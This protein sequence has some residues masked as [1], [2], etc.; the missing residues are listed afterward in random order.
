[1]QKLEYSIKR[2]TAVDS[3]TGETH[4]WW[5]ALDSEGRVADVYDSWAQAIAGAI[6]EFHS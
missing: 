4:V 1:M 2:T 6:V 3:E 5:T